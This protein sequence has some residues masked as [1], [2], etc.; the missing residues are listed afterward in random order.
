MIKHD[1]L[2]YLCPIG[3]KLVYPLTPFTLLFILSFLVKASTAM[4][5]VKFLLD[6]DRI[7][8]LSSSLAL[9]NSGVQTTE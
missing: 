1:L 4:F 8:T 2:D 7:L 6:E 5:L 9:G 3:Q